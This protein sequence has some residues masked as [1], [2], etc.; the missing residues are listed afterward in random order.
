MAFPSSQLPA[1]CGSLDISVSWQHQLLA[2]KSR[3][4]ALYLWREVCM[5]AE[6]A[7]GKQLRAPSIIL[8]IFHLFWEK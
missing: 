4:A 6:Q 2:P 1:L 7:Q 8:E 3:Y 5:S